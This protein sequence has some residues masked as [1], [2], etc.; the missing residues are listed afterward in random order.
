MGYNDPNQGQDQGGVYN[1]QLAMG[2]QTNK[3]YR[4]RLVQW[5]MEIDDIS[6][7]VERETLLGQ[8]DRVLIYELATKQ[9]GLWRAIKPQLTRI[10][11]KDLLDDKEKREFDYF[12]KYDDDIGLFLDTTEIIDE[13]QKIFVDYKNMDDLNRLH[14]CLLLCLVKL[15]V[16]SSNVGY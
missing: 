10:N 4:A 5:I 6:M 3:N 16:L 8:F 12:E 11:N 1:N 14:N 13:N 2:D 7:L 9:M 15:D